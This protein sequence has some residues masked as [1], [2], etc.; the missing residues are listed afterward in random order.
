M[1]VGIEL[2]GNRFSKET[3]WGQAWRRL[4]AKAGALQERAQN[5][6]RRAE[7]RGDEPP[8]MG[9]RANPLRPLAE[10]TKWGTLAWNEELVDRIEQLLRNHRKVNHPPHNS[11]THTYTPHRVSSAQPGL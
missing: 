7:G 6:M 11:H 8:D 9:K 2:E 4:R 1:L 10:W 5:E 3:V